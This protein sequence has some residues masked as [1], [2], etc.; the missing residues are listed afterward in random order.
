MICSAKN[1]RA[2]FSCA[3]LLM[4]FTGLA[5]AQEAV[6]LSVKNQPLQ[7]VITE[8]NRQTGYEF[9]INDNDVNLGKRVSLSV[10]N[11]ALGDV[12][13]R[14]F[15][16]EGLSYSI[17]DN[18]VVLAR[19]AE[20]DAGDASRQRAKKD[21]N[22]ISG[23]VVDSA[24]E[25]IIAAGVIEKGT[26]NGVITDLDGKFQI[27]ISGSE[28]VLEIQSLG[29]ETRN[30]TVKP[31]RS[32]VVTL[33]EE[34]N[35][36]EEA[37]V[38][39]YG[40]I[41]KRDLTGS[42]SQVK[43]EDATA[44][45]VSSISHALAGKAAGLQVTQS[46]AIP[47]AAVQFRIRGAASP[48]S[49]DPLVIIDGFPIDPHE[50][51]SYEIGYYASGSTDNILG[52]INPNDIASIEV[53]KDASATAIYGSRA[54]H[55]VIIVTTKKGSAGRAKVSYSGTG[56][57]QVM[58]G[59]Y[60]MLGAT[61]IMQE[62][63]KYAKEVWMQENGVGIYGG[64]TEEEISRP[65]TPYYSKSQIA[66]PPCDTDWFGE[67]TRVGF[68]TQHNV[69]VTGGN[70][71]TKYLISGNVFYQNGIIKKNDLG[72]YTGR[73]NLDQKLGSYVT[74][75]VNASFSRTQTD[76]VP[77]GDGQNEYASLLVAAT[78]FSPLLPV[79]DQNGGY[80]LNPYLTYIPNPA[81]LLEITNKT[82]KNRLLATAWIEV[83]P[84]PELSLKAN[85]GVDYNN[86]KHEVYLPTTTLYG[87]KKNGQADMSQ[88]EKNDYLFEFTANYTRKF[89]ENHNFT[90]LAGWS[91]QQFNRESLWLGNSNYLTDSF[92]YNNIGIGQYVKPTVGSSATK[93]EMASAFARINYSWKDRYL[94]TATIRADGTSDF[95]PAHRWG[96]FPSVSA[97]WVFSDEPFFAPLREVWSMGKIRMSY[98]QTGNSNIGYQ[99]DSY[100]KRADS[101]GNDYHKSIGGTEHIGLA[102]SQL[103]N[104]LLT[105]ETTTEWNVGLDLGFFGNRLNIT[106]EYFNRV[107][108]DLL[109]FR[110]LSK[111]QEVDSIADNIGKTQSQGVELT[112][113]SINV[114]SGDFEWSTDFTFSF[115]R[116]HWLE[117]ADSWVPKSYSI[118]DGPLRISAGYLSDG[119]VQPG[120]S[121]PYMLGAIPGQVKIK[122]IDGFLYDADGNYVVDEHGIF[123]K[124]GVP[125]GRINEADM[126]V[127]GSR[128]PD[129]LIGFNNTFNWNH[130][131]LNVYFYG[132]FGLLNSGSYKEIWIAN[133]SNLQYGLNYPVTASDV[134]R[135]D[136]QE[137]TLPGYFAN[138]S[139]YGTADY[140]LKRLWFVRCRN[141]T[142][143]YT[144]FPKKVLSKV[145]AYI[146]VNNPFIIQPGYNGFDLET[147]DSSYA[148]PNV[149]SFSL[150]VDITF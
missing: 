147:D 38:V 6:T 101:W 46:T 135:H 78:K 82:A 130:F 125:D 104:P 77:L 83:K 148:Y 57:A 45:T 24:G 55:G 114:K 89:G 149:R 25:P 13:S 8:L 69:S 108:S 14:L 80:T 31:G 28:A 141:I 105:W 73:I 30:V 4:V 37:V 98:G 60:E 91:F 36:L 132:Q 21:E 66:N 126:V 85:A 137:S 34:R 9:V 2:A 35:D 118:Y 94:L 61:A 70:E 111:L 26:G 53:L 119:L 58:A 75:G 33:Q 110:S 51:S 16:S 5:K 122:D 17:I 56:S 40:T 43:V 100:F 140:Y 63:N 71:K 1:V 15:A 74:I 143:G 133:L 120:E 11:A 116:D 23:R 39:G 138:K 102:L 92:L 68:Q 107:I 64:K 54:G 146:D 124:T 76:N 121:I 109:S 113:N 129:Y 81:S 96:F 18:K 67:L 123:Q 32:L 128:D 145:R 134:W 136:N 29:Y 95:D 48:T 27:K 12:L 103:G 117:R 144:I 79:R 59:K 3:F 41:R 97:G 112:V 47:G 49:N 52:S 139:T 150:G 93:K 131:D 87:K 42:V 99:V 106:A 20:S 115:Y 142:L 10:K 50:D 86:A 44:G 62:A 88:M 72:R 65:F 84:L 127:Y 7:T 22:L 19:K 90:A